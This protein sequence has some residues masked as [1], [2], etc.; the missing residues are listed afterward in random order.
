MLIKIDRVALQ[1]FKYRT[2]D[3]T[4]DVRRYYCAIAPHRVVLV[5]RN[6]LDLNSL[7]DRVTDAATGREVGWRDFVRAGNEDQMHSKITIYRVSRDARFDTTLSEVLRD[8][9][10]D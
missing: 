7:V 9:L 3:R 5:C 4:R 10:H 1:H 8:S 2:E 6:G